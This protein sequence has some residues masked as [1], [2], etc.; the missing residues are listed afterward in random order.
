[1]SIREKYAP[2]DGSPAGGRIYFEHS[3]REFFI[4]RQF[5]KSDSTDKVTVTD[6]ATGKSDACPPDIGKTLLGISASAFEQ[7]VFIGNIPAVSA[8][9]DTAGEI[10]QKLSETALTGESDVS[11][12]KVLKRLDD[13]RFKLI[14]KSGRTGSRTEDVAA[15]DALIEKLDNADR[16]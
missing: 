13:A 16:A 14:S 7:S 11:Y 1:M 10:N 12:A 3:G 4:E 8:D 2:W 9:G 15:R 5:R 6:V